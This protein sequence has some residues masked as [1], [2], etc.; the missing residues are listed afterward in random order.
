[1][2]FKIVKSLEFN[3]NSSIIQRVISSD[4]WNEFL[5]NPFEFQINPLND[6]YY[7]C[8]LDKN[9]LNFYPNFDDICFGQEN[10]LS[11]IGHPSENQISF[12]L[13]KSNKDKHLFIYDSIVTQNS[14]TDINSEL[15]LLKNLDNTIAYWKP[16]FQLPFLSQ[17]NENLSTFENLLF[18]IKEYPLLFSIKNSYES[19]ILEKLESGIDEIK[20]PY[21]PDENDF[22]APYPS[23]DSSLGF[24][25]FNPLSFPDFDKL[26]NVAK[27]HLHINDCISDENFSLIINLSLLKISFSNIIS[28]E[29]YQIFEEE[30]KIANLISLDFKLAKNN[31]LEKRIKI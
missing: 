10:T 6:N 25:E 21:I 19:N 12:D 3:K 31:F 2:A 15:H 28:D 4:K 5:K 23:I 17:S 30:N 13:I 14:S 29:F 1:M 22:S 26:F 27:Q 11:L 9:H 20:N 18:L 16:G 7:Y 8:L 24:F